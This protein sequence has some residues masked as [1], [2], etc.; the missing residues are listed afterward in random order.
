MK[1]R[2]DSP[3]ELA[4]M[5]AQANLQLAGGKK[6]RRPRSSK[7]ANDPSARVAKRAKGLR[8][9]AEAAEAVVRGLTEELGD[10]SV[11]DLRQVLLLLGKNSPDDMIS[12]LVGN[13]LVFE[14]SEGRYR[15]I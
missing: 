3:L 15:S 2:T 6:F 12:R 14:V 4:E 1:Y 11:E 9:P 7:G 8:D 13:N 5:V 10:F